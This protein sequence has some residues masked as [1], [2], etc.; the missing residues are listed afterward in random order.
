[1]AAKQETVQEASPQKHRTSARAVSGWH[2]PGQP[3]IPTQEAATS[4]KD[5]GLS[6]EELL[7][8]TETRKPCPTRH[9]SEEK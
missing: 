7:L 2:Q 3:A 5:I 6:E 4:E 1:M 9:K 8:T